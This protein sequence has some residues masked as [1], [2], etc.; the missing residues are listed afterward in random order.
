MLF[1]V[2]TYSIQNFIDSSNPCAR[3]Q[4]AFF[5][6]EE[7]YGYSMHFPSRELT[8]DNVEHHKWHQMQLKV[9]FQNKLEDFGRLPN[10]ELRFKFEDIKRLQYYKNI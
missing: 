9:D 8:A 4:Q 6:M 7:K 5:F 10:S 2:N 3:G 1:N